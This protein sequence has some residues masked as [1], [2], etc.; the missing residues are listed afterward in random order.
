MRD[1]PGVEAFA[2]EVGAVAV[3][4]LV[5]V[6]QRVEKVEGAIVAAH[7]AVGAEDVGG[8]QG[9]VV[10]QLADRGGAVVDEVAV[11]AA[12]AVI[13]PGAQA[14]AGVAGGH[15]AVEVG[16]VAVRIVLAGIGPDRI[17]RRQQ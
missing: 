16:Q 14:V 8:E 9:A 7:Q 12:V 1:A 13:A 5:D 11:A 17:T 6:A 4:A 10:V 15:A 3:V 2:V